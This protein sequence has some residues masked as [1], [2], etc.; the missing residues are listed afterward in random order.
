[1]PSLFQGQQH[2]GYGGAPLRGAP[3][4]RNKGGVWGGEEEGGHGPACKPPPKPGHQGIQPL[5]PL[6]DIVLEVHSQA[7][8]P[9]AIRPFGLQVDELAEK[10]E[11]IR[12]SGNTE[13]LWRKIGCP[14]QPDALALIHAFRSSLAWALHRPVPVA[15]L[16]AVAY[17]NDESQIMTSGSD[18]KVSCPQS[19]PTAPETSSAVWVGI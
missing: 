7:V 1:M 6:G 11:G 15:H 4:C 14:Y 2:L 19:A 12:P 9:A 16:Q 10:R 13:K 5:N 17:L 8:L 3:R 18:R